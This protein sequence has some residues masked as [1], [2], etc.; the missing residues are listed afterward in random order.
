MKGSF[1]EAENGPL[2]KC[3]GALF[4]SAFTRSL[5]AYF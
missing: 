2:E 4:R 5:N 3:L 1:L